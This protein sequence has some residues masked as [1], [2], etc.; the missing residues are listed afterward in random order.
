MAFNIVCVRGRGH[1]GP[2]RTQP[3]F[4]PSHQAPQQA[5]AEQE[6]DIDIPTLEEVADWL[7]KE[8][9]YLQGMAVALAADERDRLRVALSN[10]ETINEQLKTALDTANRELSAHTLADVHTGGCVDCGRRAAQVMEAQLV[11]DRYRAVLADIRAEV[12]R[13]SQELRPPF[14]GLVHAD[15]ILALLGDRTEQ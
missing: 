10:Q 8:H 15:R 3:T 4:V 2:H 12:E 9:H 5:V 1:D 6:D 14:H 7:G 13:E 11:T